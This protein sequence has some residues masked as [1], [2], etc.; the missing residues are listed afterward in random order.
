LSDQH[1]AQTS[2]DDTKERCVEARQRAGQETPGALAGLAYAPHVLAALPNTG[3]TSQLRRQALVRMQRLQGN[4]A[5]QRFLATK[6]I[7]REGG[8]GGSGD[9]T[10]IPRLP[11]VEARRNFALLILKKAYGGRI[12]TEAKVAGTA[13]EGALRTE[14]DAAMMRQGKKF[15]EKGEGGAEDQLRDW[16]PGDSAKHPDLKEAGKF[17]G[18]N[19]PSS[20]QVFVDT[21]KEPDDQVATITHE[22]LHANASPDFPGT[23]G[24]QLD[25]GMTE[26]LTKN[27]F[28]ASGYAAPSGQYES[29]VSFVQDIGA[30]VGEGTL[31]SAYFGGVDALRTMLNAQTDKDVFAEFAAAARAKNWVWMKK[32]FHEYFDK[33]K[34]GSELDKKTAAINMAL[35][36]WV[37]DADIANIAGIYQN[38][39]AE[40]KVQLR[41]IIQSRIGDLVDLG[42]RSQLRVIIGS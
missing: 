22:M 14:Y 6:V 7:Q 33:L 3:N 31:V 34:G 9:T 10:P 40:E 35:D 20:G 19:D 24:K 27:A 32:F 23:L 39:S 36:G 12:K 4:L 42:Q 41:S 15:R 16:A 2:K 21:S 37:T 1:A 8:A 11:D 26:K 29:E 38:A 5:V 25:E 28:T 17:K 18:F 13:D 30:M